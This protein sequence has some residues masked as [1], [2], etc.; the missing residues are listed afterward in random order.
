MTGFAA[1]LAKFR[2]LGFTLRS[3]PVLSV[4]GFSQSFQPPK[5][6]PKPKEPLY[7]ERLSC[8]VRSRI[9]YGWGSISPGLQVL[10]NHG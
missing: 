5:A 10:S 9:A 3:G 8:S 1:S 2:G 6:R 4:T 7:L